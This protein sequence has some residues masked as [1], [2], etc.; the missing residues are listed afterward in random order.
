MGS[1]TSSDHSL[2]LF[3]EWPGPTL[4]LSTSAED[5]LHHPARKGRE[6]WEVYIM[7]PWALHLSPRNLRLLPIRI[8]PGG[9]GGESIF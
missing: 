6:Q 1:I 8:L 2:E 3:P 9:V 4:L 7:T 5:T